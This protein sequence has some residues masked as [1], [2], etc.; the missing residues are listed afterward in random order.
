MHG[1]GL[2]SNTEMQNWKNLLPETDALLEHAEEKQVTDRLVRLWLADLRYLA[3]DMEDILEEVAINARRSEI[4]KTQASTSRKL[5]PFLFNKVST[6]M[7]GQEREMAP[8]VKKIT[9]RLQ[10]IVARTSTLGLIRSSMRTGDKSHKASAERLSTSSLPPNHVYGGE[11]DKKDILRMLLEGESNNEGGFVIPIVGMGGIGKTTLAQL[12]YNDEQVKAGFGLKAW[13]CVPTEFDVDR[14]TRAILEQGTGV[15]CDLKELTSLQERL[16]EKLSNQK[17]LLVL[18]DIWNENY[19]LW[20]NLQRPFL[21]RVPGRKIIVTTRNEDIGR[22]IRGN[23]G[24]YHLALLKD[25]ACLSLFARHALGAENFN[26]HP[27]L[28]VV[29]EKIVEKC[30]R[31]PLAL[32]TLSGLLRGKLHHGQ[33]ENLLNSEIWD[34]REDNSGILPALRLSYNHLPSFLKRCFGYCALLST[35][36]EFEEGELVLLWMAEGL[37]QQGPHGMSQ[38]KDLGHQYFR[39]LVSRA[40]FQQSSRDESLFVVHDLMIALALQVTGEICCTI[41]SAGKKL[42]VSFKK[43]RHLSF[44]PCVYEVSNRFEIL[45]EPNTLPTFLRLKTEDDYHSDYHL[46]NP[47]FQDLL[48]NLK[49]LRVLSLDKYQVKKLPDSIG[50]LQHL[51]YINLSSTL[52]ESLPDSIGF[53]V[54]LQTLLLRDCAMLSKLPRTMGNLHDLQHFDI[55]ETPSLKKM[56]SEINNLTNL[57]TL[58]KFIIGN[59]RGLRVK[60]LKNLLCLRGQLSIVNLHYVLDARDAREANLYEIKGLD[61]LSLEW[62]SAHLNPQNES[63][64]MQV[65]S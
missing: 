49:R 38:M 28:K 25:E 8:R 12:V 21:S 16:K 37:F 43:A 57:V 11:S 45:K 27:D 53:L 24:V 46:S 18:D 62:S 32:K 26:A 47:L 44:F 36:Y 23:D 58:P 61:D 41:E 42:D 40:F 39:D 31:L 10:H 59:G 56:P 34:L 6:F 7:H 30:K 48:Q 52:I 9:D 54:Y 55:T 2:S 29:G 65:L 51:R 13:V 5:I 17:F 4:V 35:D 14:I 20:E 3:Y 64:Q 50:D 33:W 63:N 22:M 60:D 15:K 1:V 19:D